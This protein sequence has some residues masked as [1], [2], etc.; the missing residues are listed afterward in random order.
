MEG[1]K[2]NA[3]LEME[4][5]KSDSVGVIMEPLTMG[6]STY[7]HYRYGHLD[8]PKFDGTDFPRWFMKSEQ[9]FEVDDTAR[10]TSSSI[11]PILC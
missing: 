7:K 4:S 5:L 3:G 11:A 10:G 8:C 1:S 9:F 6:D 2:S